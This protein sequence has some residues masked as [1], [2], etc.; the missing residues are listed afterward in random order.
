M[1]PR[2]ERAKE[3]YEGKIFKTKDGRED[4]IVNK[5]NSGSDIEIEFLGSGYKRHVSSYEFN[6]GIVNPFANSIVIFDTPEHEILGNYYRTNEGCVVQAIAIKTKKEVTVKFQDKFGYEVT[7]TI[8]N[9]RKGEVKNPFFPNKFGGYRGVGPYNGKEYEWLSSIWYNM[10][11]RS[12]GSDYYAQ[13]HGYET[14][15]YDNTIICDEWLNY[16]VFADWYLKSISKLN[17]KYSYEMDKDLKYRFYHK[18]TNGCK[19]Y[20]PQT[21]SLMPHELNVALVGFSNMNKFDM[22]FASYQLP[23]NDNIINKAKFYHNENAISDE[24]YNIIISSFQK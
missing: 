4:F 2:T 24:T 11:M 23:K 7:T 1:D 16:Q 14:H 3:K 13:Y 8:Q 12:N 9:I 15:A 22:D 17:S 19:M 6:K 10:L 5:F 21:I 18:S 20:S